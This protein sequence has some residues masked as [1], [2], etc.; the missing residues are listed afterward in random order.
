MASLGTTL[1]GNFFLGG[2]SGQGR[3]RPNVVLIVIDT[4]RADHVGTLG[5]SRATTP[6]IDALARQ[7]IVFENAVA[8]APW[9][10][11][12][13]ATILTSQYPS[14]L[15]IRD[16]PVPMDGRFPLLSEVLKQEGY[17][18][19]GIVSHSLLSKTLGFG[20]GF[21]KYDE[22]NIAGRGGVSSPSV[23]NK[24]ISFLG[25][26]PKSPF[27]LFLHYFD[28]HYNYLFHPDY[29]YD[30]AYDGVIKSGH[31]I[32][33][34]WE[35]RDLLSDSDLRHLVALYDSE[36]NYTDEH[37]GML[38]EEL[39]TRGLFDNSIIV[40]VA[41][42]GE[43]FME[44]G[45]IGHCVS[46][47]QELIHVPLIIK[48]PE[49]IPHRVSTPVGLIDI[50]PTLC[51]TLGVNVPDGADGTAVDLGSPGSMPVTPQFTETFNPQIHQGGKV[52]PIAFRGMV[53]G[54]IKLI[55]DQTTK[56]MRMFDL[57]QDRQERHNIADMDTRPELAHMLGQWLAYINTK[58]KAGPAPDCG[59]SRGIH[60]L[61]N[62]YHLYRIIAC[63]KKQQLG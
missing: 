34:L 2:C 35:I 48:L 44:R 12:S 16:Q 49:S 4:L 59:R 45:W 19:C 14:V 9:T 54:Q 36:I 23:T 1:A 62:Y 17:T 15:G 25:E 55:Y 58:R 8:A 38:L 63:C 22:H 46:L 5:Y 6:N 43:E 60:F 31:S 3:A 40:I 33:D 26:N 41:D 10:L 27:F 28:P 47:H 24:A 61:S 50:V 32:R 7:S 30:P 18:T 52:A 29:D 37:V 11:P 21:E 20:K 53:F 51:K 42:H 56:T 39:K 13:I 57:S